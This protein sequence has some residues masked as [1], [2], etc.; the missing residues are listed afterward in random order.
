MFA[1]ASIVTPAEAKS[2]INIISPNVMSPTSSYPISIPMSG[3]RAKA[4]DT[5]SGGTFH[6]NQM[7][8]QLDQ[9]NNP[10]RLSSRYQSKLK[11]TTQDLSKKRQ[12]SLKKQKGLSSAKSHKS[13]KNNT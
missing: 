9:I 4:Y 13:K 12:P 2:P 1:H 11:S 6:T 5:M 3:S 10:G 8:E 7:Q